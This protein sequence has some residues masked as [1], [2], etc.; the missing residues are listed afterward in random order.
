MAKQSNPL[1]DALKSVPSLVQ[2][3]KVEGKDLNE[4]RIETMKANLKSNQVLVR[5]GNKLQVIPLSTWKL[6]NQPFQKQGYTKV[7]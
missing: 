2:G 7:K 1:E 6:R 5:N 3:G 4:D